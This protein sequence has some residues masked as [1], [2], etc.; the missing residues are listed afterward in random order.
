VVNKRAEEAKKPYR[1]PTEKTQLTPGFF[2][3]KKK[4]KKLAI[5]DD[6]TEEEKTKLLSTD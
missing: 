3:Q 1:W 6:L 4:A 5:I 2:I